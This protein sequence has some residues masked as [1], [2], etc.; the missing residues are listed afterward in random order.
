MEESGHVWLRYIRAEDIEGA[1]FPMVTLNKQ[2][3]AL[4]FLTVI[5]HMR[6]NVEFSTYML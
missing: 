1:F 4:A 3:Y 5:Y 6:S 2:C